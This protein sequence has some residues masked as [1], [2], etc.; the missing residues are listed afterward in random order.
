[1]ILERAFHRIQ[2]PMLI[3]CCSVLD[4]S[5]F[6]GKR[7]ISGFSKQLQRQVESAADSGYRTTTQPEGPP[8]DAAG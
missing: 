5:E 4:L 7:P 8:L 1:M 2:Q 6:S 3:N